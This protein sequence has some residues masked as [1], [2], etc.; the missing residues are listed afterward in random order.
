[1]T[2]WCETCTAELDHG[3]RGERC[4]QCIRRVGRPN[5][6]SNY[7]YLPDQ[8]AWLHD[9]QNPCRG[10]TDLFFPPAWPKTETPPERKARERAA[11]S[12]CGLC[13]HRTACQEWAGMTDQYGI[14]GGENEIQRARRGRAGFAATL[15]AQ[16]AFRATRN[17]ETA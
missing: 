10:Q 13:A 7:H 2:R 9:E 8:P 16:K 5:G 11:R 3:T 4:A 17:Q 6:E 1:M 15:A 14:W 12:V